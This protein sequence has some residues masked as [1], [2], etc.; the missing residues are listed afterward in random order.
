MPLHVSSTMCSSSGGQNFIIQHLV[1]SHS[2]GGRP[3]HRLREDTLNLCMVSRTSK[4]LLI[5]DLFPEFCSRLQSISRILSGALFRRDI[6]VWRMSPNN[7]QCP[8]AV[9]FSM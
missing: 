9:E 8:V 5:N 2:V 1:S 6:D 4:K 3:V 7:R